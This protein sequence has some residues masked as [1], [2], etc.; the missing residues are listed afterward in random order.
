MK[1]VK[2]I[3]LWLLALF[4][5]SAGLNHFATPAVY[6]SIVPTYLPYPLWLVW[7]SGAAEIGLGLAVLVPRV[8][9]LAAWGL[10]ALLV[11]IFPANIHVALNDIGGLGVWNWVRL[12]F[13]GV[14][15]LWAWWYTRPDAT[16]PTALA[17]DTGVAA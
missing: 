8:R 5:I 9:V 4:Y 14:F 3:L 16:L 13:Q 1:L 6:I 7:I 11:A 12:P 17:E 15:I 2:R 10:I